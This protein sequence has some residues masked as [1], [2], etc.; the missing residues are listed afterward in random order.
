MRSGFDHYMGLEESARK[1]TAWKTS[2]VPGLLQTP[3]YRRAMAWMEEPNKSTVQVE[4]LIEVA[5]KRQT[6][7]KEPHFTLDVILWEAVLRD[8]IGGPAVMREQLEWL[9]EVSTLPNVSIRMVP[10]DGAGHL[11]SRVGSFVLLEFPK[12]SATGLTEPPVIFVEEWAGDLYLEREPE[13]TRYRNALAEISRVA[14]D[15]DTTKQTVLAMAKE[16]RA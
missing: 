4:K 16:Y 6:R 13:V 14:L 8:Q 9:I 12:L 2:I 3:E 15:P 11:G 5:A 7:L 10:F 1:V